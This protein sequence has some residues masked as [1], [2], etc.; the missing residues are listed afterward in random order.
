MSKLRALV[1]D[2]VVD[3]AETI[4]NDLELAG[5]ETLVADSGAAAIELFQKDQ[6]DVVVTD[7]R[8]K[9]VDGLDVLEGVRRIDPDVPVLIMTAFGGVDSAVEAMRRGAFHYVT[10]PFELHTLRALIERACRERALARENAVLRRNLRE[11]LSARQILGSSPP[12]RQLRALIERVAHAASPVLISGETGSGK[13]LVAL[14]IHTDGPRGDRPFV[15]LNCAALPEHLLESELFG[16]AR[17]AFTGAAQARRGLFVEAEGGT[18]FLDEV[19]D[20]PLA[21]QGKLLRVL[22]SGEVRPVGSETIRNVDVRCIAATHK[23]LAQLVEQGLFRE[24]LFFRLDVLRVVVPSL[25]ERADDIPV[26]VD[27]FLRKSVER[28]PRSTLVGFEPDALDFLVNFG[29]TGNVRQLENLIE[30]LVVTVSVPRARLADV[31]Q[32]VGPTRD[33]DPIAALVQKPLTLQALEDRYIAGILHKVG[34]SKQ[35][36]AELLGVDPSTLYR[37]EKPRD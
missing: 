28:S 33:I 22:Q 24:D 34:G 11:N 29:W 8:M 26:L 25:R 4:A 20:L 15:A 32:A 10:K 3:M 30:R 36:A 12:M 1:V 14:A 9:S 31:K 17:G 5:Y 27:A 35:K 23:D 2:D 6:T 16:H 37:R 13:E 19:G 21:L 7:L 18:L